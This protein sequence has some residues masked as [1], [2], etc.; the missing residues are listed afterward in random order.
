MKPRRSGLNEASLSAIFSVGHGIS[1]CWTRLAHSI[2]PSTLCPFFKWLWGRNYLGTSGEGERRAPER[3]GWYSNP[4]LEGWLQSALLHFIG[5]EHLETWSSPAYAS[6]CWGS[7]QLK[8]LN[9]Q[10]NMH[11]HTCRSWGF[12]FFLCEAVPGFW[13]HQM[14]YAN[15]IE[16]S[17]HDFAVRCLSHPRCMSVA[18][19][20]VTIFCSGTSAT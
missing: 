16:S 12:F 6:L 4:T 15:A 14:L 1:T 2:G 20:S 19:S 5:T 13:G 9:L 7:F 11:M 3:L 10:K 18:V 8:R 17:V